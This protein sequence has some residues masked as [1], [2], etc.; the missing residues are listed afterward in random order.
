[1]GL[2]GP[3]AVT[4]RFMIRDEAALRI[5]KQETRMCPAAEELA[6]HSHVACPVGDVFN[7]IAVDGLL[8][9]FVSGPSVEFFH[10][11]S[12]IVTVSFHLIALF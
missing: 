11:D 12:G 1:M 6:Q 5:I 4:G 9:P 7:K 10:L 3:G 2:L 8:P